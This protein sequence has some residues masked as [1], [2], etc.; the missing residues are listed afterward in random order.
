MA[1]NWTQ[2]RKG[3]SSAERSKQLEQADSESGPVYGGLVE[4]QRRIV[5]QGEKSE[6]GD[7]G[8]LYRERCCPG[9]NLSY[10]LL[11]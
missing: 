3:N 11:G 4:R 10:S 7:W 8:G 2:G 6:G 9:R 5:S 1:R